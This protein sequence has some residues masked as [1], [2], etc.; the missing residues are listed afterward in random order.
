[1]EKAKIVQNSENSGYKIQFIVFLLQNILD[2]IVGNFHNCGKSGHIS[3]DQMAN[4][5]VHQ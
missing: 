2:Q 3:Y 4:D 5:Q 1:M